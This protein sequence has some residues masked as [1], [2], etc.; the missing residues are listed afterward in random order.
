MQFKD[1]LD[2]GQ[3]PGNQRFEIGGLLGMI[4]STIK[5]ASQNPEEKAR[6]ISPEIKQTVGDKLRMQHAPIAETIHSHRSG[7][8][9]ALVA[10]EYEFA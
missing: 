5:D 9:Q 10:R 2:D 8:Y 4:S 3:G 6:L 7:P 1:R